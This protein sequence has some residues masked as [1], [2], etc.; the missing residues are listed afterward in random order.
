[1]KKLTVFGVILAVIVFGLYAGE[2]YDLG[3]LIFGYTDPINHGLD[4]AFKLMLDTYPWWWLLC[5][6]GTV[7]CGILAPILYFCRSVHCIEM[8]FSA[9]GLDV[10]LFVLNACFRQSWA[11][12]FA[13]NWIPALV[14]AFVTLTFAGYLSSRKDYTYRSS[15]SGWRFLGSR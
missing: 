12:V 14:L 8:A 15:D 4:N 11:V 1:M 10:L 2:A 3:K 13:T 6:F 7:I 9:F 5:S